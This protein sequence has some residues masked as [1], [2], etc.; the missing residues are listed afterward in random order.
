MLYSS[1]KKIN[2]MIQMVLTLISTHLCNQKRIN[3]LMIL[4]IINNNIRCII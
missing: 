4:I 3:E 2:D 1:D